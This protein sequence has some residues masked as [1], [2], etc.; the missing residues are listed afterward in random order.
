ML[1]SLPEDAPTSPV[2]SVA[3]LTVEFDT[4]QGVTRAVDD[5]SFDVF[6][7]ETL[8][9][10]GES[11]CGKTMSALAIANRP[12]LHIADEPTTAL[13][14][15][16]QAQMLQVLQTAKRE[17]DASFSAPRWLGGSPGGPAAR[18]YNAHR[19]RT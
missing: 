17:T 10:V 18:P 12:R 16:I 14:V 1:P 4:A 7:G 8:A 5:V 3:G 15:T 11:G 13:D 6:P 2:L 9:I 19:V